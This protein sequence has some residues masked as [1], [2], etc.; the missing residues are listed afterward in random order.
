MEWQKMYFVRCSMR[1]VIVI[2]DGDAISLCNNYMENLR[3][4]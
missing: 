3:L 2:L 1:I 4:V